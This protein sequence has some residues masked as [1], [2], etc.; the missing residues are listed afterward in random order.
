MSTVPARKSVRGSATVQR[1]K[2]C[3]TVSGAHSNFT[4]ARLSLAAGFKGRLTPV[5]RSLTALGG[6]KPQMLVL[7]SSLKSN[8]PHG[9][10]EAGKRSL[11]GPAIPDPR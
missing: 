9:N 11:I 7:I 4:A 5:R 8:S 6:G 3:L 2:A 10:T 1:G